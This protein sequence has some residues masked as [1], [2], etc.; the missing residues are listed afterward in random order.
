MALR[1]KLSF[2]SS[3]NVRSRS[4]SVTNQMDN[5][6]PCDGYLHK[7]SRHGRWQKRYFVVNNHYLNYY[8]NIKMKTLLAGINLFE[9]DNVSDLLP[10]L[11]FTL[12]NSASIGYFLK[13]PNRD[14]GMKW[15][16]SIRERIH[17][18]RSYQISVPHAVSSASIL[19]CAHFQWI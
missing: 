13:A 6:S 1:H 17:S 5:F 2:D 10:G 19:N 8:D 15:I 3:T 12:L 9:M 4:Q 11:E 7:K 18:Y 16:L 14:M